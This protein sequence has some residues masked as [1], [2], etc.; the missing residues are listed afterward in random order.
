MKTIDDLDKIIHEKVRLGIMTI[1]ATNNA[2]TFNFLKK[3]LNIT[4]GNLNSHLRVL[5]K[6]G[7]IKIKKEFVKRKP[8]TTYSLS[9]KGREKFLNYINAIE[10]LIKGVRN[11]V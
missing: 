7:Y 11:K 9:K 3:Q 2:A 6:E 1:L 10:D 8:Q 4:D 5:E